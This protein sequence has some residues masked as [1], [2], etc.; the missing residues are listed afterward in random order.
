KGTRIQ[1]SMKSGPKGISCMAKW[2]RRIV[3][4]VCGCITLLCILLLASPLIASEFTLEK[5]KLKFSFEYESFVDAF[6]NEVITPG[7]KANYLLKGK[8]KFGRA[9]YQIEYQTGAKTNL[10]TSFQSGEL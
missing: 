9:L 2:S 4:G 3:R 5:Q 10:E 6:R 7:L 1:N 8:G